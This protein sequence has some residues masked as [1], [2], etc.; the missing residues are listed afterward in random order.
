MDDRFRQYLI[1][2]SECLKRISDLVAECKTLAGIDAK[3]SLKAL[4][5]SLSG[6]DEKESQVLLKEGI[7]SEYPQLTESTYVASDTFGAIAA[8]LPDGGIVLI[9]GTGSNCQ[10]INP[11]LSTSR[12]GG[13]GHL[14]GDESSAYWIAQKAIKMYFDHEDN[15]IP[16]PFDVTF[17]KNTIFSYFKVTERGQLLNSFYA[18][19]DKSHIA[20]LCKELAMAAIK[21]KD[22]LVCHIFKEAG[23]ILAKHIVAVGPHID[24]KLLV[25][26]GGLHI[27]CMGS[28][29]K[30]WELLKPGF[31]GVLE[32]KGQDVGIKEISLMTLNVSGAVGAAALSAKHID[33]TLPIDYSSNADVF[34]H[35]EIGSSTNM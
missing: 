35:S 34:F 19:F 26:K 21:N 3:I 17:V 15:L 8:A 24:K 30:S 2:L 4:G 14:L 1:G 25:C 9:A 10:L 23:E 6:G 12:C 13:W 7:G 11:D 20:G 5:L 22:K 29:W 16:C 18:K 27:V 32:Q 28:V 31:L 33:I